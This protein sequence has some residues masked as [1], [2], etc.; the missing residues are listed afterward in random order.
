VQLIENI[1]LSILGALL[2]VIVALFKFNKFVSNS[3][4]A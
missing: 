1:F 2:S 4:L 3:S